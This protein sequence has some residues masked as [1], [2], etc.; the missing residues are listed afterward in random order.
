LLKI[1]A[2]RPFP[3]EAILEALKDADTIIT[4]DKALSLGLGGILLTEMKTIFYGKKKQPRFCGFLVGLGGRDIPNQSL[5]DAMKKVESD[6]VEDQ[7]ID[8]RTELIG[9]GE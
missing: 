3:K 5:I 7:F 2:F 1:R 9:I 4:F 8:L 6:T